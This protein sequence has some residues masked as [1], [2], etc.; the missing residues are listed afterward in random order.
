M[1]KNDL[2]F[3]SFNK[4]LFQY[5]DKID[6]EIEKFFD[7]KIKENSVFFS[8]AVDT[9][10]VLKDQNLHGGKRLRPILV[11]LGYFLAGGK[12]KKA[13]LQASLSVELIH[14]FF[15]I[16]DDI[17]DKDILRRGKPSLYA[18]F[19]KK[20]MNLHTGISLAIIAGDVS[21]S[22]GYDVLINSSFPEKNKIKVLD[23]LNKMILKTC[24]GEMLEVS[25]KNRNITEKNISDVSEYKT[26]YYSFFYPLKIGAVLAGANDAF[27]N[28]LEK[29][30]LL[31]GIAFQIRDD[32]LGIFGSEDKIGKP[33]CSDIKENQPNLLIFKT[34]V[35]SNFKDKQ[36]FKGYLGKQDIDKKDIDEI[37]KIVKNSGALDFCQNKAEKLVSKAK[38]SIKQIEPS[39]EKKFLLDLA[40]YIIKRRY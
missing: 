4:E 30:A 29:F 26:A 20:Y 22:L 19:Q 39:K 14:N 37:R 32:I 27:I 15:L 28:R 21:C 35:L 16:H 36:K 24:H 11:N 9:I 23:V 5:K 25:L 12:N 34:L 38:L 33:V 31:V 8:Q 7:K 18:F 1:S 40:E 6:I 3:K 2:K 17:I 13:I 10:K